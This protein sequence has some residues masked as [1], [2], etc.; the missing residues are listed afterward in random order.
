V[1][2]A[3]SAA[4]FV[5]YQLHQIHRVE[6]RGLT[7]SGRG[8]TENILLVGSTSRCAVP[9]N[10]KHLQ[11]FVQQC[12]EGVNGVNSDV[13]MILRLEPATHRVALLSIPR[14]TFVPN[15][16]QGGLYNKIDAALADGPSQLVAAIQQ[17]FGIPITHYVVLNFATF[18]G[19]VT[20]LGGIDMYFPTTVYDAQSGLYVNRTGCV[21]ISGLEALALVRARHMYYDYDPRTHTWRGYDGSGDLGRIIRDHIFLKVL[22]SE[23]ARRGLGSVSTD[24]SLLSAIAPD[25]TVESTFSYHEMLHLLLAFH[26]ANISKVPELTLPVMIDPNTYYYKGYDYG[27]VVFPAEPQDRQTIAAFL[28][29]PLPGSRLKPSS[30]SVSVVDGTGSPAAAA[31]TTRALDALGFRATVA[32]SQAPVGPISETTVRYR[33]PSDLPKAERVLA[34]LSGPAVLALG[35]TANGAPVT[36]ITGSDLGVL[37]GPGARQAAARGGAVT[38]RLASEQAATSSLDP[39]TSAA[40]PIPPYDPRAC[41]PGSH[42]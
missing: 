25:L 5:I 26:S 12:R 10:A 23:V 31:A 21:H 28:G 40:T 9:A 29:A 37:P 30:I 6:V 20:A 39:P 7:P 33:S 8:G 34:S 17:D 18:A 14:D 19:I 13:V 3:G 16:R 15:A 24:S 32:G 42:G 4:G 11:N 2:I 41:P 35:P 22:A 1:A 38:A 27:D 36:V